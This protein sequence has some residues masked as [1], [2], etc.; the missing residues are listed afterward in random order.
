MK[1]IVTI[2]PF[3]FALALL[4]AAPA[5]AQ[6]VAKEAEA[7]ATE[8]MEGHNEMMGEGCQCACMKEMHGKAMKEHGEHE[9]HA[10]GEAQVTLTVVR[11]SPKASESL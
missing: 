3:A 7:M 1:K 6:D 5:I 11:G 9:G 10:E 4:F 2:A 8:T